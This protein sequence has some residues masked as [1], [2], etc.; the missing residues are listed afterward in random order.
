MKAASNPKLTLDFSE[1]NAVALNRMIWSNK[2]HRTLGTGINEWHTPEEY[3]DA[4]REVLGNID[5]DPAS[6]ADAQRIIRAARYYTK[7]DDGLTKEWRG[8]V[9]LNP[10]YAQPQM[11]DFVAKLIADYQAGHVTAAIPLT[12]AFTDTAWFQAA[13]KAARVFCLTRGRIRFVDCDG[14]LASPTQGQALFFFGSDPALFKQVF[15][16]FGGIVKKDG[17][18]RRLRRS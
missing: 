13:I 16:P 11:S 2:L 12:H 4:A 18:R 5:L 17:K 8:T 3:I 9:F 1:T 15:R 6:N 7:D 14:E 10:P